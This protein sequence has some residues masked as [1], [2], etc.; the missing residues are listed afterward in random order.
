VKYDFAVFGATGLQ[1]R[2]ATKDLL[3]NGY[4]VLLC[5]R[6]KSRVEDLLKKYK[7]RTEFAYIEAEDIKLMTNVLKKSGANVVVNCVEGDYNLN[8]LEACIK[9]GA[10]CLDLDANAKD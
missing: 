4:S 3:W 1:G 2:I 10:N 5:G 8:I 7:G 9:T 6:D